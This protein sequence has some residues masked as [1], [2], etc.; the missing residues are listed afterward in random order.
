M[1]SLISI[2]IPLYNES[3]TIHALIEKLHS[4]PL[5]LEIIF[6]DDGSTDSSHE[7]I[8]SLNHPDIRLLC[9]SQR[10]GKGAAVQT[11]LQ[12]ATGDIVV[13]QDAD[14]EYEPNDIIPLINMIKSNQ[15]QVVYGVRDLSSQKKIIRWGNFF[16]TWVT[17]T[18]Y[19]QS[20]HDMTTCYKVMPRELMLKLELD[21]KGFMI[22]AEITA[23]LF[24]LGY[25]IAEFPINYFP[26]YENKKLKIHDGFPMLWGLLKYRFWTFS[27]SA[28]FAQESLPESI[29]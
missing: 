5:E 17:N 27:H 20:I 24:R 7:L 18:L 28:T 10:A 23:K 13:I 26:R 11:G 8:K 21:A 6:V 15:T 14:L 3:E 12:A 22:D 29:D 9:H 16:L 19:Q 1:N 4:L 25:A 2:I